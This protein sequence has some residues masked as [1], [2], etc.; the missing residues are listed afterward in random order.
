MGPS[1]LWS[2]CLGGWH[3]QGGAGLAHQDECV[4]MQ[5]CRLWRSS[6]QKQ[7]TCGFLILKRN[8]EDFRKEPS[9]HKQTPQL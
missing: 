7:I 8:W 4:H 3:A 9:Y 5:I 6:L 2:Q 1:V